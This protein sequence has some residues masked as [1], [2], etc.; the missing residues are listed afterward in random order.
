MLL[1][2]VVDTRFVPD[3]IPIRTLLS[4]LK[5]PWLPCKVLRFPEKVSVPRPRLTSMVMVMRY[6]VRLNGLLSILV[7]SRLRRFLTLIPQLCIQWIVMLI[8][9]SPLALAQNS[10]LFGNSHGIQKYTVFRTGS[11]RLSVTRWMGLSRKVVCSL[12]W[13]LL[14][15]YMVLILRFIGL[16]IR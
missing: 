1:R 8:V 16:L 13:R 4:L 14:P 15:V 9:R 12:R 5:S 10:T 3:R 6:L 2:L 11:I 7:T